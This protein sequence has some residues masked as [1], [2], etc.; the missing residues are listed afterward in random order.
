MKKSILYLSVIV[1]TLISCGKSNEVKFQC[2]DNQD[3]CDLAR[4]NND[5]GFDIF[6][7]LHKKHMKDN[8]FISPFSISTALSMTVNG[9]QGKTYDEMIRTLKY[10]G[11]DLDELNNAYK[12]YLDIVPFLDDKVKMNI[13]NSIWYR[14]GFDVLPEFIDVNKNF[15]NSEVYGRD[16]S[17]PSTKDEI[18][19]WVEGKTEG[20]IK[21]ILDQVD[22]D[23]VMFLINAIYFKGEWM[24]QFDKKKTTK[25]DFIKEDGNRVKVDMMV[26]EEMTIPYYENDIFQMIDL[27]YGDSIFSMSILLPKYNYKVNDIV[28]NLN[29]TSWNDY[30]KK[31]TPVEIPVQIPKFKIEFKDY[32]KNVLKDLGMVKAFD[33]NNADFTKIRKTGG[34]FIDD[35]IHQSFVEVD[36]KGTEAAA[37]T[38]VIIKDTSAGIYFYANR[39]FVFVIRDNR[40]NSILFIGKLMN[41]DE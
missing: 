19:G 23:A 6:K 25:Q 37:A 1:L 13:A 30:I 40:T 41:P 16:F 39:P 5:F 8:L 3:V 34:I 35:V 9:A 22:P 36:E 33:S 7:A 26:G 18:N 28:A 29:M 24:Y 2:S 11:W 27:P 15:Y 32:L 38:V 21:D 12:A 31:L 10:N 4:S 20:K 17:K 14:N